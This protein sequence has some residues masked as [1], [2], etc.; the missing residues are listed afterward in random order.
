[1]FAGDNV[2]S[3]ENLDGL[4]GDGVLAPIAMTTGSAATWLDFADGMLAARRRRQPADPA[5]P[6]GGRLGPLP[7]RDVAATGCTSRRCPLAGGHAQRCVRRPNRAKS[8]V[9]SA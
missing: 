6:R 5:L 4:R 2:Y 8:R 3:Y 7:L 1:M 9:A